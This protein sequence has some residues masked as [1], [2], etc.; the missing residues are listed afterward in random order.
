MGFTEWEQDDLEKNLTGYE[1]II[2]YSPNKPGSF[3]NGLGFNLCQSFT[4]K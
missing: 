2:S 3:N 1:V 4:T